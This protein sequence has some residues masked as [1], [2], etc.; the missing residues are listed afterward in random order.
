VLGWRRG[1]AEEM[2]LNEAKLLV[3]SI[4][5]GRRWPRRIGDGGARRAAQWWRPAAQARVA[6]E[7]EQGGDEVRAHG[8]ASSFYRAGARLGHGGAG[9]DSR[10]QL[11]HGEGGG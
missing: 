11:G 4:C 1:L 5:S 9:R 6:A 10:V 2:W 3:R 8:S 7:D